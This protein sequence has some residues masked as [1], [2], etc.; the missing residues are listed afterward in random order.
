MRGGKRAELL[1]N[2]KSMRDL[3]EQMGATVLD[4]LAHP[5]ATPEQIAMVREKWVTH[6]KKLNE[7]WQSVQKLF[8][9]GDFVQPA[10]PYHVQMRRKRK[11]LVDK[12][13][14][15]VVHRIE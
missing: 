15:S 8:H 3:D 7:V 13:S 5:D 6:R 14:T 1:H 9:T 2:W 10:P 4:L 11:E 12:S